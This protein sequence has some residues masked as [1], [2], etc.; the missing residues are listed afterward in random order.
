M[1]NRNEH[2]KQHNNTLLRYNKNVRSFNY[3]QKKKFSRT[4][5]EITRSLNMVE[6]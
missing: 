3:C 6:K 2:I 1:H 4:M 5:Y